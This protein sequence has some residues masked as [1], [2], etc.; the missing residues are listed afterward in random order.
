M[1]EKNIIVACTPLEE[2]VK[3]EPLGEQGI[4]ALKDKDKRLKLRSRRLGVVKIYNNTSRSRFTKQVIRTDYCKVH[5][6]IDDEEDDKDTIPTINIHVKVEHSSPTRKITNNSI[7]SLRKRHK[8]KTETPNTSQSE[9]QQ[10]SKRKPEDQ[11]KHHYSTSTSSS[12]QSKRRK[13]MSPQSLQMRINN[14]LY[15]ETTS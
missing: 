7:A 9:L 8:V 10:Q 5:D 1:T 6:D 12:I 3:K 4:L 15:K 14:V 2:S 13:M 11:H